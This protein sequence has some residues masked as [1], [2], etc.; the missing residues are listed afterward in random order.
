MYLLYRQNPKKLAKDPLLVLFTVVIFVAWVL[1]T[2]ANFALGWHGS[3]FLHLVGSV[4]G[5]VCA[6]IWRTHI[7][8][9]ITHP[10]NKRGKWDRPI[11]AVTLLLPVFLAGVFILAGTGVL[12]THVPP[13]FAV[14]IIPAVVPLF[15]PSMMRKD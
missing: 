10:E 2:S 15:V 9:N 11:T 12:S 5:A 1:I 8:T 4:Y 7:A 13:S 3:N 14:D 6:I